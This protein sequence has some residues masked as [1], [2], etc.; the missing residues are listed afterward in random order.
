[1]NADKVQKFAKQIIYEMY[2][3]YDYIIEDFSFIKENYIPWGLS[4]KFKDGSKTIICFTYKDNEISDES[5]KN[6][7][8]FKFNC[9]M[10]DII[11]V[12][13]GKNKNINAFGSNFIILDLINREIKISDIRME[14]I[15]NQ[16]S[17]IVSNNTRMSNNKQNAF[18]TYVIIG[19]NIIMF[20]ISAVLSKNFID[21]DTR[22]LINLGAKYN[23]AIEQ[24]QWFRL[25][26]CMFLHGGI[27]HISA[28][29]YSLYAIGPFVEQLYGKYRYIIIYFVSG[30]ISSLFSFWFSDYVSIGASGAIFGLLGVVFVLAIK[31]RKTF[32]KSFL[33]NILSVVIMNLIM[34]INLSGID[35]FAHLGGLLSGIILGIFLEV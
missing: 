18:L 3:H 16:I 24:G 30:I 7:I 35:N 12:I 32:G 6:N 29:M 13:I 21:I 1:M 14:T 5:V 19:I 33:I 22:V 2:R 9:R 26:T 17:S 4:K 27:L 11:T 20:I 8:S 10:E 28:N 25:I 31:K 15:A 34:G 23:P